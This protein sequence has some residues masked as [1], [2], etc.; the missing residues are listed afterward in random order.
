[1]AKTDDTVLREQLVAFL[2]GGQAHAKF[3]DAVAHFPAN[4]ISERPAGLPYSAWQLV[5][6]IRITLHDLLEFAT[7]AE[8][9]E[10]EW[11]SSYWPKDAAPG[12]DQSWEET[13]KAIRA[14]LQSFE[15]LVHSPDSNL[16]ATIPWG[17]NGETLLREVLLAADHT[18][19]HV[20]EL[21]LL[22]RVLG[23]WKS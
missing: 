16:Y 7:N 23:I 22:R 17:K 3:S 6:H 5:E 15:A 4:R 18:S 14:D 10:L 9:V 21:I 11:P 1:M 13:V 2:N 19:Y 12:K 8:Y 20:G